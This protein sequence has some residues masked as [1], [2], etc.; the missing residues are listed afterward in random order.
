MPT[1]VVDGIA[2]RY[3]VSG[4]GEPLLL[5]RLVDQQY[6]NLVPDRVAQATTRAVQ[7]RHLGPVF[8]VTLALRTDEDRQQLRWD[9]H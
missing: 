3:E 1:A 8:Q 6:R 2:T 9:A 5:L 4:S 7:R